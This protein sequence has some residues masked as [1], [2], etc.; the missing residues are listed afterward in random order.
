M[1]RRKSSDN[2][3]GKKEKK[4]PVYHSMK[5][6]IGFPELKL[7]EKQECA[8]NKNMEKWHLYCNT[9]RCVC[10]CVCVCVFMN[11]HIL[12]LCRTIC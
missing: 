11:I 3:V 9:K 10:V 6:A 12:Y 7:S 4:Q 2:S 5:M 8:S 1:R